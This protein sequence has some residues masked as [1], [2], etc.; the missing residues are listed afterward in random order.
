M[1]LQYDASTVSLRR[2]KHTQSVSISGIPAVLRSG[3]DR[4]R[5]HDRLEEQ[6]P[7]RDARRIP[8]VRRRKNERTLP[9]LGFQRRGNDIV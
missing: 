8:P 4:Q 9:L 7:A 1:G 5:L 6:Q 2:L 3:E